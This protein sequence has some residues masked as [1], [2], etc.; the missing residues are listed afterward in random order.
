MRFVT[1]L[2]GRE[3]NP[4]VPAIGKKQAQVGLHLWVFEETPHK[5]RAQFE[6]I[7][8]MLGRQLGCPRR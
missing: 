7:L 8:K 6:G 2:V 4:A 3:H 5:S 1:Y